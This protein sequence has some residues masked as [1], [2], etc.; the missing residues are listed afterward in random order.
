VHP[1]EHGGPEQGEERTRTRRVQQ[2][3][4]ADVSKS[5]FAAAHAALLELGEL[6]ELLLAGGDL[7][8]TDHVVS[9]RLVAASDV[10]DQLGVVGASPGQQ[11]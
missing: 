8:R 9:D 10:G 7:Q 4:L 1:T 5:L 3:D 6:R 2:A 11:G